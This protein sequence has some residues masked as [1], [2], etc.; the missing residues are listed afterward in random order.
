[1]PE[2]LVTIRPDGSTKIDVQGACGP[3][4]ADLT[5]AI[6]QALGSVTSDVKKSEYSATT[7]H[8]QTVKQ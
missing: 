5:R 7:S 4:C 8:K 3:S 1:M 2:I 6:E